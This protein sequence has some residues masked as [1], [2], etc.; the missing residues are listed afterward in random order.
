MRRL[1]W[2]LVLAALVL[3]SVVVYGWWQEGNKHFENQR[4]DRY[5]SAY[6]NP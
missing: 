1:L 4:R 3:Y 6:G 5:N 2:L